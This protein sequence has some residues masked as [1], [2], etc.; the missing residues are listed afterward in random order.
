MVTV[1]AAL[2]AAALYAADTLALPVNAST[3]ER[4]SNSNTV[5]DDIN[6]NKGIVY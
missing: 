6:N 3:R 5:L 1:A 2:M 4:Y